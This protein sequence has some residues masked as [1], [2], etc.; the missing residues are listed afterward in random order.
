MVSN[1]FETTSSGIP[2]AKVSL[3]IFL[4]ISFSSASARIH[5]IEFGGIHGFTYFPN[6]INVFVGDTI[7]WIGDFSTYSMQSTVVPAGAASFGP[8]TSGDTF[9]YVVKIPGDYAYQNNLYVSL[10]MT[11]SFTTTFQKFGISNDGREFY[12]GMLFPSYYNV[13]PA[14]DLKFFSVSA[15]ISSYYETDITVS[16]FDASGIETPPQKNHVLAGHSYSLPL[17][18]YSM[19]MD[20]ASD[21]PAYKACHIKSTYPISVM[22]I[23]IGVCAGGSYLA[24]PVLGLGRKYVA[25][26]Y[27][28]NPGSGALIG[29]YVGPTSLDYAA[30]EFEVIATENQTIVTI[31]PTTTTI[32]GHAGSNTGSPHPYTIALNRGQCYLARSTGQ[33]E[34]NDM[35]GSLIEATKPVAVISG[36]ENAF[37]GGTDPYKIEGRDFMIEQ[38]LPV[39]YW[40][41]IGYASVP[42]AESNP[43][44]N[45]GVGDMYR[46]YA[47]DSGAVN[48]HLDVQGISG[49]FDMSTTRLVHPPQQFDV[50]TPVEAYST[51]GKKIFL[52]QYDERSVTSNA[53]WPAP[54][55]M[56]I[57]PVSRWKRSYS[58]SIDEIPNGISNAYINILAQDLSTVSI[59]VDGALPATLSSVSHI[60]NFSNFSRQ[61]LSS[62]AGQYRLEAD[63][64][65]GFPHMYH[66]LSNDPFM[67]Y[68]YGN[69]NDAVGISGEINQYSEYA[70]PAGTQLNTGVTPSF[71]VDTQA[72]CSGWHVCV[73]DTGLNDPGI[74]AAILIDD[75]DGVYWQT[76]A[77]YSNVNFDS[78]STDY[79]DGELHPHW[80]TNSAYCFDVN[81]INPLIAASAPLAIVDNL[82][83]AIILQLNRTA[84]T[85]KLTTNPQTST[86]ADSIVFPVK[87][88]GTKICTSFV[89]KNTAPKNGTAINLNS[90]QLS[91]SDTS[92][93]T[94]TSNLTF[95]HSI[96]A[97]DSVSFQVCYTP[98]DSS[99]HQDTL[100][101]KSD[102]FSIPISLD[103]HGSTGLISSGDLDFKTVY[104]GDTLC[105]LIQIKNVGSAP[106]SL[107][108]SFLVS[109]TLNFTV[110]GSKL[111]ATINPGS[112]VVLN[113]C[114]HPQAAQTYSDSV[115]WNTD[116]EAAFK[117]SLKDHSILSGQGIQKAGV[118]SVTE[119]NSFTIRPNPANG[120]YVIV[121]ISGTDSQSVEGGSDGLRV[122]PTI[123]VFDVLGR[124]VY[125]REISLGT[126]QIQIPIQNL[127]EGTYYVRLTSENTT[128]T[129]SFMKVK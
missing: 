90:V 126:S 39:E 34:D 14:A 49:G 11:G 27:N 73:R 96:S 62:R 111:P 104:V 118:K 69:Y 60:G 106:F 129:Q 44:G 41:S 53:P 65:V 32:S 15:V 75:P 48:A 24:L 67:V 1:N 76:P 6:P 68:F 110:D 64:Y 17:D 87:Q 105:K 80:H 45:E 119:E 13:Q 85:V 121:T 12:L 83:N 124:E 50:T 31:T 63:T 37:L 98:A 81:F 8:V 117:H 125:K 101:L 38:M 86:R 28:D 58:F 52:M 51:K 66:L 74:K 9:F 10:G 20:T 84:P 82:G 23:S 103:A 2:I 102:C 26:S 88:I 71:I 18:I 57:I 93:K 22:Y 3:L 122:R 55:M 107:T 40:D 79:A 25:A 5:T 127:P 112:Y 35:S 92:Y 100:I 94:N 21:A 56:S 109:D 61:F 108:N 7:Q 70:A 123:V 4:V 72:R 97:G 116:L 46:V 47:F 89:L 29:Q 95:P 77:K 78:T 128:V 19:K 59:S 42:L 36:N 115:L 54:S 30:G 43:P 16:Y 120:N 114:F 113:V 33:S 99:R 91:N